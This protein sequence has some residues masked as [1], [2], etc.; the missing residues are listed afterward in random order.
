M[1]SIFD[2]FNSK[3][4]RFYVGNNSSNLALADTNGTS[5][6]E[7]ALVTTPSNHTSQAPDRRMVSFYLLVILSRSCIY[8][9]CQSI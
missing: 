9:T 7:L 2:R 3:T 8:E 6:W 4:L 5:G 1:G